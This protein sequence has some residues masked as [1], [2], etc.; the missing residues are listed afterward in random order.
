MPVMLSTRIHTPAAA[1]SPSTSPRKN[2]RAQRNSRMPP[3]R[4]ISDFDSQQ[5]AEKG[6][7]LAQLYARYVSE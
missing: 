1:N 5:I 7:R 6:E 2:G 4:K 3:Q